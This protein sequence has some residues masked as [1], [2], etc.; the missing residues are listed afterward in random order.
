[1]SD[2][3]YKM[4]NDPEFAQF[5]N[6]MKNF[7]VE[8]GYVEPKSRRKEIIHNIQTTLAFIVMIVSFS[9]I[10]NLED[11][12]MRRVCFAGYVVYVFCV[13]RLINKSYARK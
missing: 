6:N 10:Y 1:M 13:Y 3:Q 11:S 8:A 9:Y 7:Q 5:V 4:K 2:F 12:D